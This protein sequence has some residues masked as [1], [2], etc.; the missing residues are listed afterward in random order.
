M[1][2]CNVAELD[3]VIPNSR[4]YVPAGADARLLLMA[5]HTLRMYAPAHIRRVF[6]ESPLCGMSD[7]AASWRRVD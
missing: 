7:A 1:P 6:F 5:M 3:I 2:N 4:S